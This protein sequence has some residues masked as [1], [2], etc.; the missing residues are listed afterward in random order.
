MKKV[1]AL[2]AYFLVFAAPITVK[3][4][5][6]TNIT[7]DWR[8][9]LS[10]S[11][12]E[13][14]GTN[15]FQII[16]SQ[17]AA[18]ETYHNLLAQN[19]LK[20]FRFHNANLSNTW[21][22][23]TT[24]TWNADLVQ[25]A[26]SA[27]HAAYG[28][29]LPTIIQNIPNWPSWMTQSN[30]ILDPSEYDEYANFCASLVRIVNLDFHEGVV[31]WEPLNE[32]E[33]IYAQAGKLND[34]WTIFN[35]AAVAMRAVDPT[36]KV[37]GP[38]LSYDDPGMITSFLQGSGTNIDFISWHH[39]NGGNASASTSS[40]LAN[41][42]NY[43]GSVVLVRNLVN[44]YLPGKSVKLQLGEYNINYNYASGENRQNTYIGALWFASVQKYLAESGIDQATQWNAKDDY[45]GLY[46]N[47]N[48]PRLSATVFDWTNHYFVGDVVKTTSTQTGVEAF[49]VAQTDGSKSI[50]FINK[51]STST[52]VSLTS[53]GQS[54]GAGDLSVQKL[55]QNGVSTVSL[56]V[57]SLS[58][59]PFTLGAYSLFM[60][61]LPR[62]PLVSVSGNNQQGTVGKSL[63]YP[64]VVKAI[65][66]N[67]NPLSGINV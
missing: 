16:S 44:Q 1:I 43:A 46:D 8:T 12:P 11:T 26:Y 52:S 41:T 54:F 29:Q 50:L 66:G 33:K 7:V 24:R 39:Y 18:D 40:I 37:G 35:R 53:L 47:Y 51:L 67:G 31:Y 9:I 23:S 61:R 34:L 14:F 22:S 36:I 4:Q 55:D 64:L 65:D 27:Y 48:N 20:L 10:R 21:S 32:M 17:S 28:D 6:L 60:L 25:Q 30:G 5:T 19:G 56:P 13:T 59:G 42:P 45:Y 49:A 3:A 62:P 58:P 63:S 2:F 15:D 57:T 38:G